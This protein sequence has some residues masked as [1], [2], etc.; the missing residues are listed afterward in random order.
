MPLA[1]GASAELAIKAETENPIDSM[2]GQARPCVDTRVDDSGEIL[3]VPPLKIAL[4]PT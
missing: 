3:P 2:T 1:G 4:V